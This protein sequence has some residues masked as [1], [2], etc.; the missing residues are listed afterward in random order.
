MGAGKVPPDG[1]LAS[2]ALLV[3]MMVLA[4]SSYEHLERERDRRRFPQIGRSVDIGGRMLNLFCS[5]TGGPAVIFEASVPRPGYSWLLVKRET[6]KFTR[7][8]WYDRAGTGWSEL[9]PYPRTS[10]DSA[11]DLHAL[12][13]AASVGPP[14]VLVAESLAALDAHVFTGFYPGEV[15]GMVLVDGVHPDLL[16]RLPHIR[17]NAA[18]ILKYIG[19]PQTVASQLLNQLGVLRLIGLHR[20]QEEPPPAEW[21]ASEWNT[22]W[23]LT[24][25]PKARTALVQ[26]L[27]AVDRSSAQAQAAG[28]LGDRPLIVISPSHVPEQSRDSAVEA[29]LQADLARLSTRGELV[30]VPDGKEPIQYRS[31]PVV[32]DTVRK[33]V[34]E[35]RSLSR[36]IR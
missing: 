2:A 11:R 26:E 23:H 13:E 29:E 18:P 33:V 21:T 36:K 10:A 34:A 17:G 4:G 25:Q 22:I 7:A 27:P 35:T 30:M 3:T 16:R 32:V 5:G 19:K 1:F 28:N 12:V 14:Y 9:G 15:A 20:Q 31:A 6:A 24:W 8:C